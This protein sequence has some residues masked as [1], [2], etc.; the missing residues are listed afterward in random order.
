MDE[1]LGFHLDEMR[2]IPDAAS[3]A[4]A[5]WVSQLIGRKVGASTGTNLYGVLQLACEMKQRGE[6]GS[7]VTLLCD[8]G[9]RY[10]DTYY[11]LT[12]VKENIGD[13]Q[14]YL[15]QLEVIQAKG[16]VEPACCGSTNA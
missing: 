10:L 5:H 15:A 2:K 12:W 4:T 8:S 3:V 13:I 9:E 11:D 1:I 16:C 7:I 14:P 6:K